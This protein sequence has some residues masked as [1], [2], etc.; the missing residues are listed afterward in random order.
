MK[1]HREQVLERH[2]MEDRGYSIPEL[3]KL[4]GYS[5]DVLYQVYRRGLGAYSSNP[6]SVRMK[7]SYKK[8]VKAPMSQ[9]LSAPQWAQARVWSFLNNSKKHDLDLR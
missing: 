2:G 6:L 9:K 8:N 4:F 5:E 7:G 1:T 3:S